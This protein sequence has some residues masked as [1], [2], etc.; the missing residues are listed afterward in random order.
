M[1]LLRVGSC[2]S[3]PAIEWRSS[4]SPLPT[5]HGLLSWVETYADLGLGFVDAS[6]VAVCERLD[7][8]RVATLNRRDFAVV[9]PAHCEAFELVP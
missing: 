5:T 3:S 4:I 1:P 2:G 6:V 8:A 7:V 9:R